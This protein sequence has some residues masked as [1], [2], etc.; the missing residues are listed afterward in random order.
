MIS[1]NSDACMDMDGVVYEEGKQAGE[2][3]RVLW[4]WK[5]WRKEKG[6]G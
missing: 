6:K 5:I 1:Q 4:T 2:G 3:K